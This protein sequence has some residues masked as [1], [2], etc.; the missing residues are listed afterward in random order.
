MFKALVIKELRETR[1]IALAA[2]AVY[3]YLISD[4]LHPWFANSWNR[5]SRAPFVDDSFD[6][7]FGLVATALAI[8]LGLR[9]TLGES[10]GGTYPVLFHLPAS[11]RWLIGLKLLVG[12]GVL[13]ACAGAPIVVYGTW[14]ATPG[15]HPSPFRWSMTVPVWQTWLAMTAVY[16]A[17]FLSGIR[18]GGWF[19]SRL[20]PLLAVPFLI[21][22]GVALF[23]NPLWPSLVNL[24][25]DA[26][27]MSC[28]LWVV[29]TRDL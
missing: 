27:L 9:Q 5:W 3:V 24:A 6:V 22:P 7:W 18:R 25:V 4:V 13:L 14:A 23:E 11:R 19:K 29:R 26:W 20:L 12:L 28:I 8:A 15:T 17:A 16:L 2:L 10:V 21:V 1:G